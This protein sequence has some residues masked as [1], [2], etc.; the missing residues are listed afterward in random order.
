MAPVQQRACARRNEQQPLFRRGGERS[1]HRL[2]P[3]AG[4]AA[5]LLPRLGG[6]AQEDSEL[7]WRADSCTGSGVKLEQDLPTFSEGT[8][9][10][11]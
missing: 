6:Q 10:G 1:R 8:L 2:R 4:G 3:G 5:P 7:G 11:Q 9:Q